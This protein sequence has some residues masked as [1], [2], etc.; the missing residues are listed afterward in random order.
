MNKNLSPSVLDHIPDEVYEVLNDLGLQQQLLGYNYVAYG[1]DYLT[2]KLDTKLSITKDLYPAIA[3]AFNSTSSRVERGIRHS[4]ENV[5]S[6][7]DP[8]ITYK[9]FG[10]SISPMRGT[11]TNSQFLYTLAHHVHRNLRN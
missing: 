2:D 3:R 5:F 8:E 6:N 9:Y 10:N 11:V 1:I 7:V 4:I